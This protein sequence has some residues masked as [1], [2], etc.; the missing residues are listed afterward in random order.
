[1]NSFVFLSEGALLA[2]PM[3]RLQGRF[4][5]RRKR[6]RRDRRFAVERLYGDFTAVVRASPR[7]EARVLA[8]PP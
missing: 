5:R 4:H 8:L 3:P 1:M 2:V 7:A 6:K